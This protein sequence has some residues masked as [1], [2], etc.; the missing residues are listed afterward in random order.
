[1]RS[2][3]TSGSTALTAKSRSMPAPNTASRSRNARFTTSPRPSA[4]GRGCLRFF[5]GTFDA[6]R[7][8]VLSDPVLVFPQRG[9]RLA[10]RISDDLGRIVRDVTEIDEASDGEHV[11]GFAVHEHVRVADELGHCALERVMGVDEHVRMLEQRQARLRRKL[12]VSV[13][14]GRLY[15]AAAAKGVT[16]FRRR[17]CV[18]HATAIRE[19]A[20]HS[21]VG[22][23]VGGA[24][25]HLRLSG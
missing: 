10:V 23:V 25:V 17:R 5:P 6:N 20:D 18:A 4:T 16:I 24:S 14:A 13:P 2:L 7:S 3:R 8:A 9:L 11:A 21:L 22:R 1:M 19:L 12:L 15:E